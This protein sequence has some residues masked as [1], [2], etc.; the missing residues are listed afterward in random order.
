MSF[1][2]PSSPGNP[3]PGIYY[4]RHLGFLGRLNGM[5]PAL[6]H[7]DPLAFMEGKP[8]PVVFRD[9]KQ[10]V[11]FSQYDSIVDRRQASIDRLTHEF[12]TAAN[13]SYEESHRVILGLWSY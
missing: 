8:L 9:S 12:S 13:V 10:Y 6:K 7:L 1:F 5:R 3:Y 2:Q 11:Y 4:P